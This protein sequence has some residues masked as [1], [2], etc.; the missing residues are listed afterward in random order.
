MV[1]RALLGGAA[2]LPVALGAGF[3]AGGGDA[4]IS[5]VLG[6][7]VVVANFAAHGLSLAWAAG[8]SVTAVQAVALG[9]F[10]VRMGVIVG[11]LFALDRTA[12]FSP[13]VFGLTVLAATIAL[14]AYEARLVRAGLGAG[15]E[16]PPDPV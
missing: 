15:L 1:R 2:L 10:V 4:A 8:I 5:A 16:I 12:F 13:L 3:A 9:G 11:A 6:L 7:V 14:L